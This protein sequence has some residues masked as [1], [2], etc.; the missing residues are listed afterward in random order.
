[1]ASSLRAS[2]V[3]SACIVAGTARFLT[4]DL[5]FGRNGWARTWPWLLRRVGLDGGANRHLTRL[6][7][8]SGAG[9]RPGGDW[10]RYSFMLS[11]DER[12]AIGR[13]RRL[14]ARHQNPGPSAGP[15]G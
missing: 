5:D 4:K 9:R 13:K 7:P 3:W 12:T 15:K 11:V 14:L 1:M 6:C 2:A 10:G 8:E